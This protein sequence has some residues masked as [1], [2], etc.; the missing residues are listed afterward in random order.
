MYRKLAPALLA[1]L[2]VVAACATEADDA[3]VQV[4]TGAAAVASLRSAPDVVADAGTAAY[5]ITMEMSV[6]GQSFTVTG[7][8][9]YDAR[10]QR[11]SLTLDM[12]AMF[13]ELASAAGESLPA[14]F[15]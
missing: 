10:N 12:G 5:E 1:P 8:G 3:A 2:L 9:A 6:E 14:G 13:D 7:S 4:S 11:M 15:D